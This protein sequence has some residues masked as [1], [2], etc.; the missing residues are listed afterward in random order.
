MDRKWF[1]DFVRVVDEFEYTET[2]KVLVRNLKRVHFDL[3]RLRGARVYFRAR[4]DTRFR[5]FDDPE[6]RTLREAFVRSER[7]DLLD[8]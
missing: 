1:P 4:G 5:P 3:P 2:Q 7:L 8:R 6:Y